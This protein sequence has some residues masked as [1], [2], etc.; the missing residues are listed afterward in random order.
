MPQQYHAAGETEPDIL[1]RLNGNV[2]MFN[3]LEGAVLALEPVGSKADKVAGATEGHFAGLDGEGNLTDSGRGA[4]DFAAGGHTHAWA[5]LTGVPASFP[6]ASH[7]HATSEVSGLENAL[8]GRQATGEKGQAGGYAG[9][10][11]EG[12]VRA[13]QLPVTTAAEQALADLTDVGR[14]AYAGPPQSGAPTDLQLSLAVLGGWYLGRGGAW[15][16]LTAD[17]S[18]DVPVAADFEVA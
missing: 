5:D 10:D 3:A 17:V 13:E 18:E 8:A 15:L 16:Q 12:K 6:P 2:E 7:T 14:H 9:L 11:D 1:T 4:S